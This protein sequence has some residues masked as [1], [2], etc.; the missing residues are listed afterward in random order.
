MNW[1]E[2]FFG[3]LIKGEYET[4]MLDG[5][6]FWVEFI[7]VFFIGFVIHFLIAEKKRKSDKQ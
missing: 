1:V 5:I 4:S 2:F 7:L 3:W 6:V